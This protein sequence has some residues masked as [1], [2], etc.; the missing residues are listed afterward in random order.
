VFY[1]KP[2]KGN[3]FDFIV[4][5]A[6]ISKFHLDVKI[7]NVQTPNFKSRSNINFDLNVV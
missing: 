7:M 4:L 2:M 1:V 6:K 5:P 3:T